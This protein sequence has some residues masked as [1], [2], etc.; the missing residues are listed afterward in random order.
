[1]GEGI[2]LPGHF[3]FSAHRGYGTPLKIPGPSDK[4][5]LCLEISPLRYSPEDD[6]ATLPDSFFGPNSGITSVF[7]IETLP[8]DLCPDS[9]HFKCAPCGLHFLSYYSNLKRIGP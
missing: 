6:Q 3:Q 7:S 4:L 8:E 9:D 1:M 2:F 5:V